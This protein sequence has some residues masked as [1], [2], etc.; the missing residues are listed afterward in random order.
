MEPIVQKGILYKID[1][2][3]KKAFVQFAKQQK[4]F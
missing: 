2:F 1:G 4:H 3:E